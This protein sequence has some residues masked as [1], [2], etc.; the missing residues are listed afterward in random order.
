MKFRELSAIG[1]LGV[2]LASCSSINISTD[3]DPGRDFSSYKTYRWAKGKERN[4][5]NALTRNTL[6]DRRVRFAVD[7]SLQSKGFRK[8]ENGEPDFI[9]LVQAAMTEKMQIYQQGGW[10]H[11]WGGPYGG[12]TTVST[13]TEGTLVV[14]IVDRAE[15]ALSWR[16]TATG[17]VRPQS[18]PESV[19]EDI[20]Y[21]IEEILH[22]FPPRR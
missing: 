7:K 22:D 2:L 12:Y 8:L 17:A 19:Q 18:D 5:R 4:P 11:G 3:Y 20:E 9:V 13:Y 1:L 6:L 10:Y 16:G 21:A 14:D 15:K